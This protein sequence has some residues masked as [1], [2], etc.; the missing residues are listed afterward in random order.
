M[1][2]T[3]EVL[4]RLQDQAAVFTLQSRMTAAE[5]A[6]LST[7]QDAVGEI[8]VL[9]YSVRIKTEMLAERDA[10]NAHLRNIARKFKP[11]IK[12]KGFR[13]GNAY[14][15]KWTVTPLTNLCEGNGDEDN[16]ADAMDAAEKFI[17][18]MTED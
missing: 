6:L 16:F 8:K 3:E 14:R 2:T 18:G 13:S 12:I 17:D 5:R 7:L 15:Y 10:E 4:K 9:A 1:P 11:R